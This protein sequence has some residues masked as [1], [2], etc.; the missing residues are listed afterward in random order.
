MKSSYVLLL[1]LTGFSITQ[2][3]QAPEQIITAQ[4]DVTQQSID[5]IIAQANVDPIVAQT[6]TNEVNNLTQQITNSIQQDAQDL[7]VAAT[8]TTILETV[9]KTAKA[10]SSYTNLLP[11]L[12][13]LKHA[14][15]INT[16]HIL[17]VSA[18][19]RQLK[20]A[21]YTD[22]YTETIGFTLNDCI[23]NAIATALV[24]IL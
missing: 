12:T 24:A 22:S 8:L 23:L 19:P 9:Q 18:L 14:A 5:T 16:A 4:I 1:C 10:N 21:Y 11:L 6:L 7:R 2:G 15:R 3:A 17:I 20:D 13:N